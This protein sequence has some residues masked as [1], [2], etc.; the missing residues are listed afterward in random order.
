[1]S[2][3]DLNISVESQPTQ[4]QKRVLSLVDEFC[5]THLPPNCQSID[6]QQ[7][8]ELDGPP[9]QVCF[10]YSNHSVH[11]DFVTNS[12]PGKKLKQQLSDYLE[13]AALAQ[14]VGEETALLNIVW[15]RNKLASDRVYKRG[16]IFSQTD[17]TDGDVAN[18]GSERGGQEG[19][20][21]HP[22]RL[23]LIPATKS[24]APIANPQA[25]K[26]K[27]QVPVSAPRAPKNMFLANAKDKDK[28]AIKWENAILVIDISDCST[29]WNE[30]RLYF[31]WL[32]TSGKSECCPKNFQIRSLRLQL[33]SDQDLKNVELATKV[34]YHKELAK[35][36]RL[37]QSDMTFLFHDLVAADLLN[38]DHPE[39]KVKMITKSVSSPV[40]DA[41]TP[42]NS[43]SGQS[44]ES[45]REIFQVAARKRK[46]GSGEAAMG[47]EDENDDEPKKLKLEQHR[48]LSR[49]RVG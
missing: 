30:V 5:R 33:E 37:V 4:T 46:A 11:R 29:T 45:M 35:A 25:H 3:I 47:D 28:T 15:A 40:A 34:L 14:E 2:S 38:R 43:S 20:Q 41:E 12:G 27:T 36:Y 32:V 8:S 48:P 17:I 39:I 13:Y 18:M 31:S 9:A 24:V 19:I 22:Q 1:M 10:S 6:P 26:A 7:S 23:P 21:P 44:L 16:R 49:K 42:R